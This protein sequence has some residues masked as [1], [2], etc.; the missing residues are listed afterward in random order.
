MQA[1]ANARSFPESC[2]GEFGG[3]VAQ[4]EISLRYHSRWKLTCLSLAQERP[5]AVRPQSEMTQAQ[6]IWKKG[7]L[8]SVR[9][10]PWSWLL[11]AYLTALRN[12]QFPQPAVIVG[13]TGMNAGAAAD[14]VAAGANIRRTA[15][16]PAVEYYKPCPNCKPAGQGEE[17]D[18]YVCPVPVSARQHLLNLKRG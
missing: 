4:G 6:A 15:R 2:V 5:E 1:Q 10:S 12:R 17:P 11:L 9:S 14:A 7:D 13:G 18:R 16:Q 3:D 8:F